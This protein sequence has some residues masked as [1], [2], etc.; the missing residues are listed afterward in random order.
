GPQG[1]EP[2]DAGADPVQS[3]ERRLR[4]E[5][6]RGV[7]DRLRPQIPETNFHILRLHYWEGWTV[8]AIAARVGL[9]HDQVWCRLHRL[10]SKVRRAL[11]ASL[12]EEFGQRRD[13]RG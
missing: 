10:L 2:A 6:V 1:R 3:S 7:L 9:T 12:G 5:V 13:R 4:D 11:P 8:R